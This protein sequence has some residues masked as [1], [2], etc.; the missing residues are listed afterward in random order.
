MGV[1]IIRGKAGTRRRRAVTGLQ[2]GRATGDA[3][4]G[5]RTLFAPV[6]GGR[7][8]FCVLPCF[9]HCEAVGQPLQLTKGHVER[10]RF[11]FRQLR[12]RM[13]AV[14]FCGFCARKIR[15]AQGFGGFFL[16]IF[17]RRGKIREGRR[18]AGRAAPA[19]FCFSGGRGGF[20][21]VPGGRVFS[22]FPFSFGGVSG[23]SA[24]AVF[25]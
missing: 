16:P 19:F 12:Q 4:R 22:V 10:R 11:I 23:F 14:G 24:R 3:K 18:P 5:G 6:G 13:S 8:F 9:S 1:Y 15:R 7:A 25:P 20:P 21:R 2:H 17:M